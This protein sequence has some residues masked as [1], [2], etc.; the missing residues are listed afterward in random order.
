MVSAS[1]PLHRLF[2]LSALPLHLACC[3][4]A[5]PSSLLQSSQCAASPRWAFV[6]ASP[7]PQF[8]AVLTRVRCAVNVRGMSEPVSPFESL[9]NL[10]PYP[11]SSLDTPHPGTHRAPSPLAFHPLAAHLFAS[12]SREHPLVPIPLD[13]CLFPQRTAPA[14]HQ[15]PSSLLST[16]LPS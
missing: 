2:L 6:A 13:K 15:A 16:T 3:I 7:H 12:L 14:R 11:A 9:C 10:C 5:C 8:L 1:E 4:R